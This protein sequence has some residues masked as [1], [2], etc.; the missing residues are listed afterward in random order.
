MERD[1][2]GMSAQ[3]VFDAGVA[4]LERGDRATTEEAVKTLR[5][6]TTRLSRRLLAQLENQSR[7]TEP[8]KGASAPPPPQGWEQRIAEI[9][10]TF[11]ARSSL[12]KGY[13]VYLVL[14][15]NHGDRGIH[16]VYVGE[17]WKT[18]LERFEEHRS[19]IRAS[20][21]VR[22]WG[23]RL[24]PGTDHLVD[25]SRDEARRIERELARALKKAGFHVFGGH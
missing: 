16:S 13:R 19:G 3:K 7:A 12:P 6:R 9:A 15:W 11:Q 5:L 22:K 18:A 17:T 10:A 25:M 2:T 1:W 23:V 21:K 4:A 14:C 8:Q 24:I 20:P